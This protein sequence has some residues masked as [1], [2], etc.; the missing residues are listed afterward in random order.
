MEFLRAEWCDVPLSRVAL[1]CELLGGTDWG[2]VDEIEAANA[3]RTALE[4]GV[5][6]FDT[7]DVYGLGRSEERLAKVLGPAIR[8]V[9]VVTK[10]GI[11]WQLRVDGRAETSR[12]LSP[13]HLR[14]AVQASL[15]RLGLERIPLYL[16]HW[17]DGRHDVEEVVGTLEQLRSEG[18]I[19]GFGL[20]NFPRDA[21]T[22]A[23]GRIHAT[24]VEHSLVASSAALIRDAAEAGI[25]SLAYGTLAQGLLTGRYPPGHPFGSNDRRHRL[26]RFRQE[27][28]RIAPVLTR[29]ERVAAETARSMAQVAVRWALDAAPTSCVIVG[30]RRPQQVS[31]N[32]AAVSAPLPAEAITAL[33]DVA[34]VI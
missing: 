19:G 29:L 9:V 28:D 26:P 11:S 25:T 3:V 21:V 13:R 20:S 8:E 14:L 24:E 27:R 15:R 7:A 18:L 22:A 31:E 2:R 17:P 23:S 10:G 4:L 6:V 5:T 32:V 12:D 16:A 34:L 30:G 33:T 1:G